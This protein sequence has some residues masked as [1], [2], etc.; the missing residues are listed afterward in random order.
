MTKKFFIIT[1]EASGD[2]LGAKIIKEI[3]SRFQGQEV[4]FVGVGG[5]MMEKEGFTSIF[6]INE[7]SIMGFV[8]V[9]PHIFK[10]LRRIKQVSREIIKQN[11]DYVITIDAPD[12]NFRVIKKIAHLKNIKKIHIIAPSVWAYR[13]SR[14]QKIAKL[15]D[16]LLVIL[17]FEPPYFTKYGLKTEFIGHFIVENE[18]DFSKKEISRM[19]FRQKYGFYHNDTIIYMTPG[20]RFSEVKKIFPEFILAINNLKGKVENLSVVIPIIEKTKDLVEKMAL[21]FEVKYVLIKKEEKE[22][23]LFSCDFALAKSGTNTI[24]ISLYKLP[25]LICYKVNFISYLIARLLVKIKFANLVNLI[26]SK[27]IIPELLQKNC[28][29]KIIE[30]NLEFL[31]KNPEIAKKQIDESYVALRSLGL[32]FEE[33]PSKKAIDEILKL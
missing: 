12:F 17:P 10:I 27:M 4:E 7:L 24:E 3:K 6:D 20:S 28:Y 19:N 29:H 32:G 33:K 26:M 15:Y 1:G 9:L 23:A 11:P 2:L 16:L 14:A 22:D 18:P 13:E 8:E 30:K 25:M 5:K 31:I 21:D